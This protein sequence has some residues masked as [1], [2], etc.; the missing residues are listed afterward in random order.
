MTAVLTIQG[1]GPQNSIFHR[2]QS[3]LRIEDT[4]MCER[5]VIT[6]REAP[7]APGNISLHAS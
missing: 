7:D 4:E 6:S 3:I 2:R 5:P 1:D